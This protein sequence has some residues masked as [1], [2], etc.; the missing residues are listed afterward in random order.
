VCDVQ[1]EYVM[2]MDQIARDSSPTTSGVGKG[3]LRRQRGIAEII[4]IDPGTAAIL[5]FDPLDGSSNIPHGMPIGFLFGIAKRNLEGPGTV[6]FAAATNT[7]RPHVR[8]PH[9]YGHAGPKTP[10]L[11]SFT[12]ETNIFAP[13]R[14]MLHEDRGKWE[15]CFN[16]SQLHLLRA[17]RRWILDNEP[18]TLRYLG[19]LAGGLHRIL[20]TAA[21]YDIG[22]RQPSRPG[23]NRPDGSC[24]NVSRPRWLA[25]MCREQAGMRVKSR[26]S[27]S[28]M[29][30]PAS[31]PAHALYV[32]S[33]RSWTA[34]ADRP[35][36]GGRTRTATAG[37]ESRDALGPR[38]SK[39]RHLR[40]LH[41]RCRKI[42]AC[43]ARTGPRRPAL[44]PALLSPSTPHRC[45]LRTRPVCDG[46]ALVFPQ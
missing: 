31:S 46:P 3:D 28:W 24:A 42:L 11:G 13:Q 18:S 40:K 8:H 19:A 36:E 2:Q 26:A 9:R 12:G 29:S 17:M 27:P 33:K 45:R 7:S 41:P 21:C 43:I 25:F 23:K 22:H 30:S 35:S 5:Y 20:T 10:A 6:S 38:Q 16:A 34:F 1:G 37:L 4:P 44:T 14:V 15:L 32:G 39:P